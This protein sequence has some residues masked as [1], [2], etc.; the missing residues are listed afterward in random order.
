MVG[1]SVAEV[2]LVVGWRARSVLVDVADEALL[3]TFAAN[4]V[5]SSTVEGD[6]AEV[7][8][9]RQFD[10]VR[11]TTDSLVGRPAE[12]RRAVVHNAA[13]H[14]LPGGRLLSALELG[15]EVSLGEFDDLCADCDLSLAE[16]WADWQGAPFDGGPRAVSVHQRSDRFNVHDLTFEARRTIRRVTASE[17]AEQMEADKPPIVVD[18]RTQTDRERF[19]VIPGSIHVPRTVVEWHLDPANGYRH[20]QVTSLHQPLVVVCNGGYSSSLAACSLVRL[21]FTDVADLI[22]GVHAWVRADLP[23]RHPDHSHLDSAPS[24][25]ENHR[26]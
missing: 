10:V 5:S 4:G 13:Q 8:L 25:Q 7:Q 18:T 3:R 15:D 2:E 19:G 14:L 17:L 24:T 26:P 21:G 22:G 1:R 20:P 12:D 23:V 6:L 11:V 9:A 16:R